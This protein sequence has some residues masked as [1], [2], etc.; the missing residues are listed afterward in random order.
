M[1]DPR[2]KFQEVP[3][4]QKPCPEALQWL[5]WGAWSPCSGTC[6]KGHR[7][8]S[9][10]C[11]PPKNGGKDCPPQGDK[12]YHEREDCNGE[13]CRD[14]QWLQW[15]AWSKCTASC[16]LGT[17]T[18]E[19]SCVDVANSDDPMRGGK[20]CPGP[21]AHTEDCDSG[22]CAVDG[23][24]TAWQ[25]WGACSTACGDAGRRISRRY[26]ANPFPMFG[27]AHCPGEGEREGPCESLPPC[28]VH[29]CYSEW[30]AWSACSA[31]CGDGPDAGTRVRSRFVAQE[32]AHGGLE[33]DGVMKETTT[34]LHCYAPN[35]REEYEDKKGES[36]W[37]TK[38]KEK[39]PK[40][41]EAE[42]EPSCIPYCPGE[43]KPC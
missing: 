28:P 31:S 25:N 13:P 40:A 5:P 41:A 22:P 21:A 15:A 20:D 3:C 23:G 36:Y 1:G 39:R 16:G 42:E 4:N 38:P 12:D 8:R 29:C 9:R 43:I 11:Y 37:E 33:C 24:W 27:G 26:C 2:F 19:R 34:C 17:R 10:G 30:G 6:G 32:A 18:R 35:T 14:P 7:S